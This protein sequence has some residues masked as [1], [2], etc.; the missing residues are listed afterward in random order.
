[1][2]HIVIKTI[3]GPS[4]AQLQKAA[5][6]ISAVVTRTMGKPEKYV[7]VSV[8]EYSFG[9]WEGVYNEFVK[10]KDNVLVQPGYSDPKTFN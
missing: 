3:S 5:E 1:M 7:S 2:P 4:Q 8:E 10:D 6:E 9:E